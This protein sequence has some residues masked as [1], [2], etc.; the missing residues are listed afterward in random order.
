MTYTLMSTLV[1]VPSE[2]PRENSVSRSQAAGSF[3]TGVDVTGNVCSEA[4]PEEEA[5]I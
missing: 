5:H 1:C 4:S 3:L 2:R